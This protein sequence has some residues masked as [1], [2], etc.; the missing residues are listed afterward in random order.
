[1]VVVFSFEDSKRKIWFV[2][3]DVV[4]LLG[5]TALDHLATHDHATL[6]EIYFLTNLSHHVPLVAASS[7]ER[8][9][10]EFSANVGLGEGLLTQVCLLAI[11][12]FLRFTLA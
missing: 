7:D 6:R 3:K 11:L 12:T 9:R 4:D 1:M 10:D 5:L 8:G 2:G